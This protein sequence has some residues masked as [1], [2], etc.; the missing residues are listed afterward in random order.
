MGLASWPAIMSLPQPQPPLEH[1][2]NVIS[3][4]MGNPDHLSKYKEPLYCYDELV[5][6]TYFFT[7][8]EPSITMVV[9][10]QKKKAKNDQL[11]QEFMYIMST[12]L[13][14]WKI[15]SLLKPK[16]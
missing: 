6:S 12:N 5:T 10:Y 8:V 9:I 11:T 4:I 7:M 16:P 15:F 3:L 13:R 2:P 1:W 14:N